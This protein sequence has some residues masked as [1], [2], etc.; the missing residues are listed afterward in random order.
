MPNKKYIS[1]R[2]KEYEVMRILERM[3]YYV[4][5]SAGSR[6]VD[7]VAFKKRKGSF[8]VCGGGLYHHVSETPVFRAISVKYHKNKPSRKD[9]LEMDLWMLPNEVSCEL[10]W[11]Q[12]RGKWQI[13]KREI[14]K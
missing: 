6:R 14:T 7:I 13:I 5:R 3:G 4:I 12:P 1:G 8:S 10:W 9:V 2:N 11:K